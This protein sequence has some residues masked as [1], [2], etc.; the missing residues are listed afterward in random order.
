[1]TLG[2]RQVR[3]KREGNTLRLVFCLLYELDDDELSD[4]FYGSPHGAFID[5][6]PWATSK[7]GYL[8]GLL[9]GIGS[10]EIPRYP[11]SISAP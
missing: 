10:V 6:V 11:E 2:F 5:Q 8:L 7:G 9:Y 4:V 1:M 3:A